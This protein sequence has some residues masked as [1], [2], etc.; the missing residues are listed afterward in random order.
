VTVGACG[1]RLELDQQELAELRRQKPTTESKRLPP[2]PAV[3]TRLEQRQSPVRA[4]TPT[5][6]PIA[7]AP[8]GRIDPEKESLRNELDELLEGSKLAQL[9][10]GGV[11]GLPAWLVSF[12][13]HLAILLLLATNGA[14]ADQ[15][16]SRSGIALFGVCRQ[17]AD[18]GERFGW[19]IP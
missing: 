19:T 14:A 17:V 11:S 6:Q 12:L 4:A 5:S 15:A 13:I 10:R 16:P 8:P 18:R 9:V 1:L 2:P 7:E 3:P